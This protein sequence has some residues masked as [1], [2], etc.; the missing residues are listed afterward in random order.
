MSVIPRTY[1]PERNRQGAIIIPDETRHYTLQSVQD[2]R[3]ERQ[4]EGDSLINKRYIGYNIRMGITFISPLNLVEDDDRE[5][6]DHGKEMVLWR[7]AEIQ[8]N[9]REDSLHHFLFKGPAFKTETYQRI[10]SPLDPSI[11]V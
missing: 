11:T 2:I 9:W 10:S 3:L 8:Q 5:R 1:I 6:V 7:Q 4:K